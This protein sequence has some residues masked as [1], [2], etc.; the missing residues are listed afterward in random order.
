VPFVVRFHTSRL[1]VDDRDRTD[2][3]TGAT[4]PFAVEQGLTATEKAAV[5]NA[6]RCAP[7]VG[8]DAF[9]TF[10]VYYPGNHSVQV[11]FPNLL[12]DGRVTYGTAVISELLPRAAQLV[13]ELARAGGLVF[14]PDG[15]ARPLVPSEEVRHRVLRRWPNVMVVPTAHHLWRMI[16]PPE[17]E[18]AVEPAPETEAVPEPVAEVEPSEQE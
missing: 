6:L 10:R 18:P 14:I 9:E 15:I 1:E 7:A 5:R 2:P 13:F 4:L 3:I 11:Q 12:G 16:A 17:P 8:P